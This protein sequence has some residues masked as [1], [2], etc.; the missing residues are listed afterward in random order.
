MLTT[1]T[2]D[3]SDLRPLSCNSYWK[4]YM[5]DEVNRSDE[6]EKIIKELF[7]K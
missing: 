6:E 3:A 4:S 5:E 2:T 1:Q 7:G